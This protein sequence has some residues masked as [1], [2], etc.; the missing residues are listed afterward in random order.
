MAGEVHEHVTFYGLRVRDAELYDQYRRAMEPILRG[1]G[2][3]FG[4]DLVVSKVLRSEGEAGMNRVF[5]MVFASAD[6]KRRF[7]ALPEYL[8]VRSMY[9]ERAVDRVVQLAEFER[10]TSA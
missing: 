2:G 5:T 8:A 9:F 7:F 10:T 3:R 6:T 4:Y 1:E